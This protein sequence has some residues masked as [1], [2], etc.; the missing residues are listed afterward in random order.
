MVFVEKTNK[1][2]GLEILDLVDIDDDITVTTSEVT[3]FRVD[4]RRIRDSIISFYNDGGT[5]IVYKI[6]GSN[7]G[8]ATIPVDGGLPDATPR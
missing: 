3:V 5:A 1:F 2:R 8:A 4:T 6:F 7:N